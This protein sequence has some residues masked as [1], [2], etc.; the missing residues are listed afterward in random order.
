MIN[1]STVYT[2]NAIGVALMLTLFFSNRGRLTGDR[3]L[4]TIFRMIVIAITAC[5]CDA[6]TYTIDGIPGIASTIIN[7]VSNSWLYLANM[8]VARI[9][10]QF[11]SDHLNESVGKVVKNILNSLFAFAVLCLPVNIFVPIVFSVEN[12]VYTRGPFYFIFV[13]IAALY[14]AESVVLYYKSKKHIGVYTLFS[15]YIFLI[16]VV[17]GIVIQST[18]YG[19]SVI[20]PSI[21]VAIAGVMSAMKNEVIFMDRL[22]GIYNRVYLEF[23]QKDLTNRREAYV[24][25]MMIDLNDFKSIND[26]FGHAAGD[27]ALIITANTLR[28]TV[29]SL[30]SVM[31]YAG[32]EFVI[33]I[34]TVDDEVVDKTIRNIKRAFEDFNNSGKKPYKLSVSIG[35]SALDLKNQTMNDFMNTIDKKMYENKASYYRATGISRR[36]NEN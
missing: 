35:Y 18:F 36:K 16:P 7:Y 34:N 12:N 31:R 21:C 6:I 5:I 8:L 14:M 9:W 3:D 13:L 25:G 1:L 11:V 28:K 20:W 24:T 22:T 23:L 4:M 29:G 19:V 27:E 15:V 32:D 33:L 10:L 2:G 17:L 30:G 26:K